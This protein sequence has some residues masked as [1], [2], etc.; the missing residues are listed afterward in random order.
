LDIAL[1]EDQQMLRDSM[2]A[3]LQAEASWE[4]TLQ[5]ERSGGFDEDLW[6]HLARQGWL[7]LAVPDRWGGAGGRVTEVAIVTGE[8]ARQA[9]SVPYLETMASMLTLARWLDDGAGSRLAEAVIAGS[10]IVVP[11]VLDE[12]D[13][14]GSVSGAARDAS[15]SGTRTSVDYGQFATHFLV[16]A[17]DGLHLVAADPSRVETVPLTTISRVPTANLTFAGASVVASAP[18][19]AY[20]EV[21]RTCRALTAV[22]CLGYSEYALDTTVEYVKN[23]VQ[24][25]RPLGSFQAVQHHC[26]DMA[27]QVEGTRFLCQEAV[28]AL[29]E[30][31]GSDDQVGTAKA[32]A[33]IAAIEVT[34][35]A[36]QLH[37]GIG[38]TEEYP[39]QLYSRRARE[40]ASAWGTSDECLEAVADGLTNRPDWL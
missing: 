16:R 32:W 1:S 24:F 37:G 11:A 29:D 30:G 12:T 6:R 19:Q 40:R 3:L 38:V 5:L 9:V 25:G 28:W 15:F 36:H 27:T 8:L 26:A 18:L 22:Q 35:L 34:A 4:R 13:S 39:L 21:E 17:S 23:R 14:F 10:A 7:G 33:G 31:R 20:E 2:R